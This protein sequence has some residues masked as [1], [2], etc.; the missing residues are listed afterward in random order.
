[1]PALAASACPAEPERSGDLRGYGTVLVVDDEELVR[2]MARFALERCG[3]NVVIARDGRDGVE[4]FRERPEDFAAVLLD[5][6]MPVMSGED[7]LRHIQ[8]VRPDVPVLLTSGYSEGE[9]MQR[10]RDRKLAGFLQKPYTA[11]ILARRLKK[12]LREHGKVGRT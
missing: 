11:T 7:A 2:N 4:V 6:T 5:L 8:E 3:Y 9:A 10:F 12:A 1:M